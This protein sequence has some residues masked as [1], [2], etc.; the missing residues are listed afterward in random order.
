MLSTITVTSN[1]SGTMKTMIGMQ[2]TNTATAVESDRKVASPPPVRVAALGDLHWGADTDEQWLHNLIAEATITADV[3]VIL[4]DLTTHGEPRQM[5]QVGR[6]FRGTG[7]PVLAVLGN[8]DC[9]GG[10][11]EEVKEVLAGHGIKVLDGESCVI[12]GVG[13][14]GTKGFG[15]GFGAHSLTAFGE[16]ESKAFVEA[17]IAE[18]LKLERALASLQTE[19]K[20]VLLHYSPIAETMGDEPQPIWPFLGS[21]RL[22]RPI[23]AYRANVV[24][25]GHAHRGS[26][27]A[28]TPAGIP[29]FNVALPVLS[30]AGMRYFV[31][32]AHPRG[33]LG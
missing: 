18:E 22:L 31:W 5:D 12:D 26:S 33:A 11:Q 6:L 24:F 19:V 4:G 14:A 16:A 28:A 13:F 8:H 29:V 23:E 15:G 21:S 30:R 2:D 20:V 7:T 3:L 27:E 10:R 25:H 17:A 32:D 1:P 9:E